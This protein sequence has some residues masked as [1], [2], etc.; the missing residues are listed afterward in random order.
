MQEYRVQWLR[1]ALVAVL[2]L[3]TVPGCGVAGSIVHAATLPAFGVDLGA[4]YLAGFS[5]TVPDCARNDDCEPAAH[6]RAPRVYT[7]WLFTRRTP[8]FPGASRVELL[9]KWPLRETP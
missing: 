6:T 1:R 5:A 8:F 7:V 3:A 9:L 2:L 4:C